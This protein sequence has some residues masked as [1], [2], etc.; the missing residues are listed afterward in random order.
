MRRNT[1]DGN[2]EVMKA[3]FKVLGL[4]LHKNGS[5]SSS[6]HRIVANSVQQN[7]VGEELNLLQFSGCQDLL[8]HHSLAHTNYINSY[9]KTSS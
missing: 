5:H 6:V 7:N 9:L 2:V 4:S 3:V 8:R 1:P